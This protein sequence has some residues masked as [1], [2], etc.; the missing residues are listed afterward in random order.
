MYKYIYIYIIVYQLYP[1]HVASDR[2][3]YPL[4][5]MHGRRGK[6][7]VISQIGWNAR[8]VAPCFRKWASKADIA[9]NRGN[10]SNNSIIWPAYHT[11]RFSAKSLSGFLARCVVR[12][13]RHSSV[14][15]SIFLGCDAAKTHRGR[16]RV[17][18]HGFKGGPKKPGCS[19]GKIEVRKALQHESSKSN[20]TYLST[21]QVIQ[22][23]HEFR[24]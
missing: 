24:N 8:V 10:M 17:L 15:Y 2:D 19:L 18:H 5:G 20:Q 13:K 11:T 14:L 12:G 23:F 22:S 16:Q 7:L 3:D 4:A 9:D 6:S 21:L 1:C